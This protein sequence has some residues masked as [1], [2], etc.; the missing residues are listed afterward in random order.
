[1]RD[2]DKETIKDIVEQLIENINQIRYGTCTVA[3]TVH[4]TNPTV[5]KYEINPHIIWKREVKK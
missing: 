5:V 1:M 4:E 3:I 2:D